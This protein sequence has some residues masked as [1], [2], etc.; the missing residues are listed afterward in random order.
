MSEIEAETMEA[1]ETI[2]ML[3]HT[4]ALN[5]ANS[6]ISHLEKAQGIIGPDGNFKEGWIANAGEKY[7]S[8]I[9][10]PL[11]FKYSNPAE[12]LLAYKS[13]QE[14]NG[15]QSAV[16]DDTWSVEARDDWYQ[17]KMGVPKLRDEYSPPEKIEEMPEG[18]NRHSSIENW[19]MEKAWE[20]KIKPDTAKT[21]IK[22]YY[23]Q[24]AVAL[25]QYN[26]EAQE[27]QDLV[28]AELK[29][30][31]GDRGIGLA[32]K[33]AKHYSNVLGIDLEENTNIASDP[34]IIRLMNHLATEVIGE[35]TLPKLDSET[36]VMDAKAEIDDIYNNINNSYHKGYIGEG[37]PAQNKRAQD[38]MEELFKIKMRTG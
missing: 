32:N 30:E 7:T 17:D 21:L 3:E 29:V 26:K 25:E 9:G 38:R 22:D 28:I 27:Q 6:K 36:T 4:S 18:M 19:F 31:L 15:K 11:E 12:A 24:Q 34:D 35:K 20:S 10:T 14:M 23:K 37:T 33:A 16:P 13:L 2:S 1:P 5:E 8:L